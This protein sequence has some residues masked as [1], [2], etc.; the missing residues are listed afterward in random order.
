MGMDDEAMKRLFEPFFTGYDVSHH[1]T[2]TYE[3]GRKGI[4]LGLTRI[5]HSPPRARGLR[6]VNCFYQ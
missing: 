1:S 6:V 3:Y 2:G 4:G 5:I